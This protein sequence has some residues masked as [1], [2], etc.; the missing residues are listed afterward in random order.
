[1]DCIFCKIVDGEIPAKKVMENDYVLAFHDIE[2]QAPVHI[3]IIP[4]KHIPAM[5]DVKE[6]DFFL[7][8]EIHKAAQSIARELGLEESGY[9][10][11]NNCGQDAGQVVFHLHYH[12]LGGGKLASL[13]G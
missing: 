9:R 2:P 11:V 6:E 7:I 12:L 4:K 13:S 8:G 5:K 10:L 1:M 3:L